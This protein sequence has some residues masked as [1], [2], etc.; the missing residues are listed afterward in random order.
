MYQLWECLRTLKE[1]FYFAV[2]IHNCY[3]WKKYFI[4]LICV[5]KI[6]KLFFFSKNI[7]WKTLHH[8]WNMSRKAQKE[9]MIELLQNYCRKKQS[10][11]L[12]W[13]WLVWW[14]L[15]GLY[16]DHFFYWFIIFTEKKANE[17]HKM[18]YQKK[19]RLSM[20]NVRTALVSTIVLLSSYL[21][22]SYS[23]S[24]YLA[25]SYVNLE[26]NSKRLIIKSSNKINKNV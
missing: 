6:R 19:H 21:Y 1:R 17:I 25:Y 14:F 11:C 2:D 4:A 10:F 9:K 24:A 7:S 8:L 15:G 18:K 26:A 23:I 20:Y 12:K 16:Y 13:F 22:H 3:H 5:M